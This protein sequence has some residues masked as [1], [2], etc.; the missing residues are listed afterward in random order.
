MTPLAKAQE[1]LDL[2]S[3][4]AL[5]ATPVLVLPTVKYPQVGIPTIDCESVIVGVTNIVPHPNY[6]P[7]LCNA[8]RLGTFTVYIIRDC[9]WVA[10]NDDGTTDV[11]AMATVSDKQDADGVLLWDWAQTY[12]DFLSKE[13]SVQ[14]NLTDGGLAVTSLQITTGID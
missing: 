5:T 4:A 6:E 2:I 3:D 1:I 11:T 10:N 12:D 8:S 13:W 14:Y 9:S 7:A